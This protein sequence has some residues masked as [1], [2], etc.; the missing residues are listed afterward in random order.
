[1]PRQDSQILTD[2]AVEQLSGDRRLK[3]RYSLDLP[4]TYQLFKRDLLSIARPARIVNMSSSGIALR[5]ETYLKTGTRLRLAVNWPVL[6]NDS[7]MLKLIV[8]GTVV[9]SA[10]TFAAVKLKRHEFRTAGKQLR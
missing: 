1:V 8:E 10:D 5:L 9:R 6:L 7:C 3:T 4:A 2:E